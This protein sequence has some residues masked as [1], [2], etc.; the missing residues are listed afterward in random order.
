MVGGFMALGLIGG[1]NDSEA[2]G[3]GK[4]QLVVVDNIGYPVIT[5]AYVGVCCNRLKRFVKSQI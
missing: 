1:A 5:R 2:Y 4:R 3:L